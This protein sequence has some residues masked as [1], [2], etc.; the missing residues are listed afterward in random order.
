MWYIEQNLTFFLINVFATT[1]ILTF[2]V[3][4]IPPF[5]NWLTEKMH[6]DH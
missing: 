3:F 2:L 1:A 6:L 5:I 4:A